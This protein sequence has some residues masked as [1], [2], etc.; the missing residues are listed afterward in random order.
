MARRQQISVTLSP[1]TIEYLKSKVADM[2][3][4]NISHGVDLCVKRFKESEEGQK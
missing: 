4:A 2:T 3:F 1:E